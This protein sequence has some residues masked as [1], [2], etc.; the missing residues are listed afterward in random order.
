MENKR[1]FACK[2]FTLLKN[3]V[4]LLLKNM[5]KIDKKNY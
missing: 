1:I 2:N 4:S 3:A 5:C